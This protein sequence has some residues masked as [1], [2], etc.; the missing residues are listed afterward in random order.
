M[1]KHLDPAKLLVVMVA[2]A[3]DVVDGLRAEFADATIEVRDYREGLT[4]PS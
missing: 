2:T 4:R 1:N 3:K